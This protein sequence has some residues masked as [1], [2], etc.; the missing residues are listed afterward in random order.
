M[1]TINAIACGRDADFIGDRILFLTCMVGAQV[2]I[3]QRSKPSSI[4]CRAPARHS[5]KDG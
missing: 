4:Y 3:N 2:S 1:Q 5:R